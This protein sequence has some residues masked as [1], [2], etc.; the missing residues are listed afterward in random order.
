[1]AD[2]DWEH[3]RMAAQFDRWLAQVKAKAQVEALREAADDWHEEH[4]GTRPVPYKWLHGRADRIARSAGIETGE[5]DES[6]WRAT[7]R[8]EA[9][10]HRRADRAEAALERV[11]AVRGY[12]PECDKYDDDSPVVC[13][14][15]RTVQSIDAALEA[16]ADDE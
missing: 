4:V 5:N 1:M 14:W 7:G 12:A 2:A 13:G 16:G 11:R 8:A 3:E 9:D 15:K 6:L 10:A